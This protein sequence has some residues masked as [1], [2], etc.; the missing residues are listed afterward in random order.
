V[1]D[2]SKKGKKKKTLKTQ[3]HMAHG[4]FSRLFLGAK[5]LPFS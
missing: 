4:A 3:S 1:K 2:D 5:M